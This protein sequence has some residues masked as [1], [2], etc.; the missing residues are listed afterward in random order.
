MTNSRDNRRFEMVAIP[1]P[2][3]TRGSDPSTRPTPVALVRQTG[4]K[5]MFRQWKEETKQLPG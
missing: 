3:R 2:A 5:V 4:E 1:E